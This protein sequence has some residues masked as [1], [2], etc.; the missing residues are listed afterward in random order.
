M[1]TRLNL[2]RSGLLE[3]NAGEGPGLLRGLSGVPGS[4]KFN[5]LSELFWVQKPGPSAPRYVYENMPENNEIL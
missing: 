5:L 1:T 3:Q 2:P 4:G